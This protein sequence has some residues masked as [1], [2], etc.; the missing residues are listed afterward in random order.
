MDGTL[1]VNGKSDTV[2]NLDGKGTV[3]TGGAAGKL[4][5]KSSVSPG[6]SG[7]GTLTVNGGGTLDFDAAGSFDVDINGTTAGTN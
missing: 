7:P 2:A 5:V 4:T 6:K 1:D 3:S